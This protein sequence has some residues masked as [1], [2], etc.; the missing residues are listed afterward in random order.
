MPG[1]AALCVA[2]V[3]SQFFRA[4]LAVMTPYLTAD[5]SMT[6]S[7]LA[8]AS[9]AWFALF[10]LA[11][12][13]V[14][15]WLDRYGP[16]GTAT[17]LLLF[18]VVGCVLF[19]S[20]T[21][22]AMVIAAMALIGIGCS[23]V[24]MAAFY[25]FARN[26]SP[27]VFAT[28]GSTFVGVGSLGNIA[29]TSPFVAAIEAIG[30]RGTMYSLAAI[31]LASALAVFL[32]V[33]NPP[34]RPAGTPTGGYRELIMNRD[35]WP[36][37]VCIAFGYAIA[38]GIRGLWSGPFLLDVF[39]LDAAGIGTSTLAIAMALVAGAFA[40]GPA[41]R[42]FDTRKWVVFTGG[43]VVGLSCAALAIV[44]PQSLTAAVALMAAVGFF[45]AGYAV[46]MAH[47]RAF[48]P[49]HLTGRGVTL[50]NFF[51]IGGAG[52]LQFVTGQVVTLSTDPADP[53]YA[54]RVL[55]A[56]YAVVM[57]LSLL[58]YLFSRDIRPSQ[59]AGRVA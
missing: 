21:S 2:Y 26:F 19:A 58:V 50:M 24:L 31:S 47:G 1:I 36:V 44:G 49:T 23:A 12:F 17:A 28:W 54:Y 10:A 29:G 37:F 30:W 27:A 9:G 18:A 45:G 32:L 41:D 34:A 3:L 57:T 42:I 35:L 40:F 4:C 16:K 39:A 22:P 38:A 48:I 8:T 59:E 25:L 14:G 11:Q 51:S 15:I 43:A 46:Q 13:P 33:R 7:E 55:F 56:F 52:L 20:A 6:A 5:L 53:A